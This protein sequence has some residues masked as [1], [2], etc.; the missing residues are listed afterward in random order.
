M[1]NGWADYPVELWNVQRPRDAL[2]ELP[3]WTW[4]TERCGDPIL[5]LCCGT[6]RIAIPLAEQGREVLG[7]DIMDLSLDRSFR[8]AIMPDWSFQVLLTQADQRSFLR[9][10]R[11]TLIPGGTFA[12]NPFIP[13]HRE[14]R[15]AEREGRYEWPPDPGY[16]HGG[17][18]SVDPVTQIETRV[19]PG[20]HPIRPRHTTLAELELPLDLAGSVVSELYGGIDR[21]PFTGASDQDYTIIAKAHGQPA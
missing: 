16:H 21:R 13:F 5:D 19:E 15:L 20:P 3:F 4:C 11:G 17:R 7:A 6:G 9:S 18:R 12:F 10:L 1:D 8:L 2:D 14:R